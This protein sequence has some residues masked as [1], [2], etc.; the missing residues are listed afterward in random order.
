MS[1]DLKSGQAQNLKRLHFAHVRNHAIAGYGKTL[2]NKLPGRVGHVDP[3]I[4][5]TKQNS[6]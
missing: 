3:I 6:M 4:A 2:Q 1:R 5:S